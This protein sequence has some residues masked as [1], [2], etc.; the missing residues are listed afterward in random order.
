MM[1]SSQ[2]WMKVMEFASTLGLGRRLRDD[3]EVGDRFGFS[4][5]LHLPVEA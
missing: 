3:P 4:E 1:T 2:D 5:S